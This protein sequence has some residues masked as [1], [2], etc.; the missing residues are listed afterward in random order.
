MWINLR[1]NF[2]NAEVNSST[3]VKVTPSPISN[4]KRQGDFV[5]CSNSIRHLKSEIVGKKSKAS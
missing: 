2:D 4:I 3:T 1:L 5:C